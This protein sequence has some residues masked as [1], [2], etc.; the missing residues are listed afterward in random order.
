MLSAESNI[1]TFAVFTAIGLFLNEVYERT[2]S[3]ELLLGNPRWSWL[4]SLTYAT[5]IYIPYV[6]LM[7]WSKPVDPIWPRG[8]LLCSIGDHTE[9]GDMKYEQTFT[10]IMLSYFV[11]DSFVMLRNPKENGLFLIHH[12]ACSVG[13]YLM[14]QLPPRSGGFGFI[15]GTGILEIGSACMN[16]GQL[17]PAFSII[18]YVGMT[19]SN[20]I[21]IGLMIN[22]MVSITLTPILTLLLT[23]SGILIFL[24]QKES[25]AEAT[26]RFSSIE[27]WKTKKIA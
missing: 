8:I 17:W 10:T 19:I 6:I 25:N 23:I 27:T 18:F 16:I 5:V 4:L 9:C 11:R 15:I 14:V 2:F 22:L 24:R 26:K 3:R 1:P 12:V 7:F 20:I 21:C 13:I